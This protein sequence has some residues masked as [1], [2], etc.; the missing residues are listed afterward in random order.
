MS[1]C[2]VVTSSTNTAYSSTVPSAD[3][4]SNNHARHPPASLPRSPR[5]PMPFREGGTGGSVVRLAR[6]GTVERLSGSRRHRRIRGRSHRLERTRFGRTG[7]RI[8]EETPAL[9]RSRSASLIGWSHHL[10]RYAR[11]P[12][13]PSGESV[14]PSVSLTRSG[15]WI[16][17]QRADFHPIENQPR[18]AGCPT[19]AGECRPF[20]RC[21]LKRRI[22]TPGVSAV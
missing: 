21:C 12:N 9:R 3:W 2:S 13:E 5:D 4:K 7:E 11:R 8:G 10:D 1:Y 22:P 15:W 18:F 20:S 17:S 16:G 19:G 14:L 6:I